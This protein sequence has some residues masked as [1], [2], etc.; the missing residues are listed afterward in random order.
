MP[1]CDS[2]DGPLLQPESHP[3]GS[4]RRTG[5]PRVRWT[6]RARHQERAGRIAPPVV[7]G[8]PP[9]ANRR[10]GGATAAPLSRPSLGSL[11]ANC[12]FL[13]G[14]R[15]RSFCDAPAAPDRRGLPRG[16][17]GRAVAARIEAVDLEPGHQLREALAG[18]AQLADGAGDAP[19]PAERV[20]DHHALQV[21]ADLGEGR[22]PLGRGRRKGAGADPAVAGS[23]DG[24]VATV[25]RLG[26]GA[27]T[28]ASGSRPGTAPAAG[29]RITRTPKGHARCHDGDHVDAA[30]SVDAPVQDGTAAAL[31]TT[32]PVPSRDS[33]TLPPPRALA[34]GPHH[35]D[36]RCDALPPLDPR[37]AAP[38]D[39]STVTD[40]RCFGPCCERQDCWRPRDPQRAHRLLRS[41]PIHA[42]IVHGN[43]YDDAV[44]SGFAQQS[45]AFRAIFGGRTNATPGA[46]PTRVE[47]DVPSRRPSFSVFG[48]G[49]QWHETR[50]QPQAQRNS[51]WPSDLLSEPDVTELSVAALRD[52]PKL[53]TPSSK[54]GACGR[55][56]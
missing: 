18:D 4:A 44:L 40:Q 53:E 36:P 3:A 29:I 34:R 31:E 41:D 22:L 1:A 6:D 20:A 25:T 7:P 45:R 21:L 24:F 35:R 10:I 52:W 19:V 42:P 13:A 9:P 14:C 37:R 8:A 47:H 49:C 28:P 17:L 15:R 43:A 39:D 38:S 26:R 56:A 11:P 32:L 2:D 5:A 12:S 23:G 54:A 16:H 27:E 46:C 33:S 30:D 50:E 51:S 55:T 48:R